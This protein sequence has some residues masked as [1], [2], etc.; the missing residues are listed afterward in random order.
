[1]AEAHQPNPSEIATLVALLIQRYSAHRGKPVTRFRLARR[2]LRK[3]AGRPKLRDQLVDKWLEFMAT[4][5]GWLVYSGSEEFLLIKS[6]SAKSWTKIAAK[7]VEDLL[8]RLADGDETALDEARAE[9]VPTAEPAV[10][11]P[12]KE[13]GEEAEHEADEEVEG[14]ED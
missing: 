13:D 10:N 2:T 1:M 6:G 8:K 12:A 5:H 4:E 3:M 7:R 14:H 11:T 9:L